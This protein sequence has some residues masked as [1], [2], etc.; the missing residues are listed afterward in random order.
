MIR[1]RNLKL[2]T[3]LGVAALALAALATSA[4]AQSEAVTLLEE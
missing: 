4:N 1:T 2:F 3:K